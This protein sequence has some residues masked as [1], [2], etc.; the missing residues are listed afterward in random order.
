MSNKDM[1]ICVTFQ[2]RDAL[3]VENILELVT[4]K[5]LVEECL[6]GGDL[7]FYPLES[8]RLNVRVNHPNQIKRLEEIKE[9]AEKNDCSIADIF[10]GTI[11]HNAGRKDANIKRIG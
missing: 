10:R 3:Q 1:N 8:I 7:Y 6:Q 11:L 9:L 2:G 5:Y 4:A